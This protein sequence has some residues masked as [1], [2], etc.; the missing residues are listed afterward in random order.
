VSYKNKSNQ[1]FRYEIAAN[2]TTIKN[3]VVEVNPYFNKIN[4]SEVGTGWRGTM[5]AKGNPVWYFS[6]YK[7]NGIFQN[8][9]EI[10]DYLSK[11][12]IT[13]YNPKPGDPV[14]V[15][16]NG[17][18]QISPQDQTF[19]GSPHPKIIYGARVDLA[20]KGFDLIAFVQGQGG[21]KILMGFN[22]ADRSTAN[23]PLFF[24]DKR[25]TGDGSTNSWF[26]PNTTSEYVYN[27]DLM[28]FNGSYMRIRQLQLG[29]T[30]PANVL[31]RMKCKTLRLYIS[32]DDFFTFTH[33]PGLDAEAGSENNDSQG[34]DRGVYPIPRKV[35][36][37]LSFTF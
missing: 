11:N 24:Y 23:K 16:V 13:G 4:G 21:N 27:S 37:G 22:R 17:D 14:V 20:Y 5:F 25:W 15:D 26:A 9:A 1:A 18:K 36:G 6:G 31:K 7:T 35:L 12:G 32:L 3:E 10:N 28:V 8:Q 33:Y 34:I 30:L 2:L 19:I 29:Y